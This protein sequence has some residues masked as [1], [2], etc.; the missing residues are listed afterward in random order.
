MRSVRLGAI[1]L[2]LAAAAPLG[3]CTPDARREGTSGGGAGSFVEDPAAVVDTRIG[4]ANGGNTF[5]GAVVPFGMVQLSPETTR[6]DPTRRPAAGGYAWDAGRIRGFALTHLSGTGCRGASG[7]VPL[8]P[9]VRG[10]TSSPSADT[11]DRIYTAPIS[12]HANETARPGYYQVRFR[13]GLNAELTATR[14]TGAARFTFPPGETATVLVR[15]SDSEVGSGDAYVAV[16][17]ASRTVTGSVTS[18]NFCAYIE[19]ID[20]RSYYT[21]Y[22]VAVF[23]RPFTSWGTWEDDVLRPGAATAEGG[24]GYG[25]EGVPTAGR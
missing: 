21:L 23:D 1:L 17:P 5:P 4:S 15:T 13:S 12:S 22:F 18:G 10:V 25:P 19:G 8:M 11:L 3:S 7:D 9:L 16:D 20:S 2:G 14:R 6:G 24:T